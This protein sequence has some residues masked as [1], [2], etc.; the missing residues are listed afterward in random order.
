MKDYVR[1][2]FTWDIGPWVGDATGSALAKDGPTDRYSCY[3]F[4]SVRH[5][6][7]LVLR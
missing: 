7:T 4:L 5:S 1:I 2:L 3:D 6:H